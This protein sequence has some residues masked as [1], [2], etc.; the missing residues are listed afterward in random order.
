MSIKNFNILYIEIRFVKPH[1]II[2]Y[3]TIRKMN[4]DIIMAVVFQQT[5]AQVCWKLVFDL[6]NKMNW[7]NEEDGEKKEQSYIPLFS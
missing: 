3:K 6:L 4:S 7:A 2:I 5:S 1:N